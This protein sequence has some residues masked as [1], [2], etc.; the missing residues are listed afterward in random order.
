MLCSCYLLRRIKR[1]LRTY[2]AKISYSKLLTYVKKNIL[3]NFNLSEKYMVPDQLYS[4]NLIQKCVLDFSVQIFK[5]K[6][7]KLKCSPKMVENLKNNCCCVWIQVNAN[8]WNF[9][10]LNL[11]NCTYISKKKKKNTILHRL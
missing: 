3:F 11:R 7:N 9:Y 5:S 8:C 1:I 4:S 2:R 6:V 10:Y